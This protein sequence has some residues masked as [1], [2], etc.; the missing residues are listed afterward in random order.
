MKENIFTEKKLREMNEYV[1]SHPGF[2]ERYL[3]SLKKIQKELNDNVEV[4]K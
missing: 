3:E 1:E 2:W 4:S